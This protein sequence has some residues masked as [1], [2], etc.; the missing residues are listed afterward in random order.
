MA[1]GTSLARDALI[2]DLDRKAMAMSWL[3]DRPEGCG[4]WSFGSVHLQLQVDRIRGMIRVAFF[5]FL[6]PWTVD[7]LFI[8]WT[9]RL[10]RRGIV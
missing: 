5:L 4:R 9:I 10:E 3:K 7:T 2:E 6:L 8:L 1:R